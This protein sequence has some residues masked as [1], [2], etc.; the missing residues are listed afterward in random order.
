M[1]ERWQH[2]RSRWNLP[3]TKGLEPEHSLPVLTKESLN[4][5]RKTNVNIVVPA[6][7]YVGSVWRLDV[8]RFNIQISCF[9]FRLCS[10]FVGIQV[11]FFSVIFGFALIGV[12]KAL[13]FCARLLHKSYFPPATRNAT[14]V[15]VEEIWCLF[16]LKGHCIWLTYVWPLSSSTEC[17]PPPWNPT[18]IMPMIERQWWLIN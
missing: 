10:Q 8:G 16:E 14:R 9:V 5:K 12:E 2:E 7:R 13:I 6:I 17:H 11:L 3:K 4:L 15:R 18:R 1:K